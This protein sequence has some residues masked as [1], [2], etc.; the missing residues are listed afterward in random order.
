MKMTSKSDPELEI[1]IEKLELDMG[2]FFTRS[3]T[4]AITLEVY[5]KYICN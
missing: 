1:L 4:S 2:S 3:S 5:N